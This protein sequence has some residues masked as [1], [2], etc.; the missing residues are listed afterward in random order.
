MF[1]EELIDLCADVHQAYLDAEYSNIEAMSAVFDY[2]AAHLEPI[3]NNAID[4]YWTGYLD[5]FSDVKQTFLNQA[6]LIQIDEAD[7]E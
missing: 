4:D 7:F 2:L 5:A 3:H 6:A 1:N